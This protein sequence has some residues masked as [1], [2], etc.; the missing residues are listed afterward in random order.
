[1]S[2][3]EVATVLDWHEALN[4]GDVDRLVALSHDDVGV[5]GPRGSGSGVH[6]LREWVARAGIRL[7]PGR[8]FRRAGTVVV[9]QSARWRSAETGRMSDSQDVACVFL[10]RDGRV[11]SVV[12][13]SDLASAL[14][15]AGLEESD[16]QR[17]GG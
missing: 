14:Q 15:A 12:R 3:P 2:T 17:P 16:E 10:V 8:V 4:A 6:V 9:E 1:M 11:A 7:E 5:G 13:Y